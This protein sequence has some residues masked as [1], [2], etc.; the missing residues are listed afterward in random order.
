MNWRAAGNHAAY[1]Q[2]TQY[3]RKEFFGLP[4]ATLSEV[5]SVYE[6][7]YG[8]GARDYLVRTLP[9]WR[10]GR[11]GMS[12]QTQT[13]ILHCVPKFL[14][15]AKQFAILSFYVPEFERRV[16]GT[17]GTRGIS[18]SDV[19]S[20]FASIAKR[21]RESEPQLDWF[22]QGVF[23]RSEIAAFA[24]VCRFTVLDRLQ[25]SY[26]AVRLDLVT[27]AQAFTE[28]DASVHLHYRI[29][30]IDEKVSLAGLIPALPPHG[31][32]LPVAPQL[33][34]QNRGEY[35]RLLINHHCQ[36]VTQQESGASRNAVAQLDIAI[37]GRAI[38]SL[39]L[40]ESMESTI[41]LRGA[42]GTLEGSIRRLNLSSLKAKSAGRMA[43]AGLGTSALLA[44]L[45]ASMFSERF[46]GF[47]ACGVLALVV[48]IPI[49][50]IW[51]TALQTEVREY[52][53]GHPAWATKTR[54]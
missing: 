24:N 23:S 4:P 52:E 53:R 22:V 54:R 43:V 39:S 3:I 2:S 6:E 35:E 12:G 34:V 20:V 16:I 30:E 1:M 13:R 36:M 26:A 33:I 14:S 45:I 46:E 25:R 8:A 11:V 31:F 9:N 28:L 49:M 48:G 51:A 40:R 32:D 18:V 50:W 15:P 44:G 5:L 42:G 17:A 47:A 38:H 10:T 21:C 41:Q 37:I 29:D 7:E 27:V 19:P